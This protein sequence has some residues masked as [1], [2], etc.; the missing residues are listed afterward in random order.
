MSTR[1][2]SV[3]LMYSFMA[4]I[5]IVIIGITAGSSY[6]I[7]DYFFKMKERD[8][9]NKGQEIA[10]T[11]QM[12]YIHEDVQHLYSYIM[13]VDRLVGARVWLFDDNYK[14]LVAS[15]SEEDEG[16]Y[17]TFKS[18]MDFV[19]PPPAKNVRTK[20]NIDKDLLG[21]GLSNKVHII[22]N[23]VYRG[24]SY[25]SQLFHPY[26]KKQVIL[27]GVPYKNPLSGKIGAILLTEPMGGLEK[28][29][30]DVFLYTITVGLGALVLSLFLVMRLSRM[31]VKPILRMKES[32]KAMASGDYS[33]KVPTEGKDE[34]A[35]LG[36]A[37]NSLSSDLEKY[38]AKMERT[39]KIR[40]DFVANVSHELRTPIT[41]I[42]GYNEAISDGI[43]TEQAMVLRYRNLINEE[44]IR[45]ERMVREL[46]D[47]SR[48]QAADQLTPSNVDELPI[49]VIIQNV[50][51][52][53]MV[54]A[55]EKNVKFDLKLDQTIKILGNGDQMVQLILILSDNALK[56]SPENGIVSLC[57]SKN[58]DGSVLMTVSDQGPG[59]PEKDIPF[60]WERFYKVDKSHS[61][62]VPGT[63]L[64]LAIA[65]EIIRTH[66]ASANVISK[67]GLGT[68]FEINF[69]KD[70]VVCC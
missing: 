7:S 13:A 51:E 35:E 61:R 34:I 55:V 6:L 64:G 52:K 44:T 21:R 63:G 10:E 70:K 8:L 5:F 24:K 53:L 11:I 56:Y 39:E 16:G 38:I 19:Y 22:L 26:Y 65:K 31:V 27:V 18:V 3:R 43:V 2:L 58:S 30:R 47:I 1:P 48:L 20:V 33:L 17:D 60:I 14:L 32:A 28:M 67:S 68:T 4:V 37:L 42:R 36:H 49:S 9:T 50:A 23:D 25:R 57:V 45:L 66:G 54:K 46:L 69:P 29:L 12:F 41:I 40:R 59:I 62:N 15:K